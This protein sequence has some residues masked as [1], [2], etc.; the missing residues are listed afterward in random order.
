V[1]K[2]NWEEEKGSKR[3]RRTNVRG[4]GAVEGER[5]EWVKATLTQYDRI[6]QHSIAHNHDDSIAPSFPSSLAR[7]ILLFFR[8]FKS[9]MFPQIG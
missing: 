7:V 6:L 1:K 5:E 2:R 8:K 3:C 9:V 4:E